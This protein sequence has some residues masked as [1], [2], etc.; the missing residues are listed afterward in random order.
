[1]TAF[2]AFIPG[3][4][5]SS[6][7]PGPQQASTVL[8]VGALQQPDSLNV[9]V[10]VETASYNIW[11]HVYELLV[12]I[13]PDTRPIPALAK[14]WSNVGNV[15]TFHLQNNVTWHDG[16]EF[17]SEDVNFTFRYIYPA[18][19][20]NPTGCDLTLLQGYIGD[21]S[22]RVG[23]DV[24][25]ITTPDKYTVVIPTYQGKANI[26]AMFVQIL[27]KHI[28]G[29]ISCQRAT[30]V[31]PTP[32][33]G[34]G[35]YKFV[36]WV[37]GSYVRLALNPNYWR[38]DKN[39]VTQDKYVG[40]ILYEYYTSSELLYR[41]FQYGLIDAT[42]ALGA[43]E[44]LTLEAS[45]MAGVTYLRSPGNQMDEVGAC[46]AS[47]A[48]MMDRLNGKVG[49]RNWLV[50][51]RTIRQAMQLAVD[52]QF[53]VDNIL[54]T[55]QPGSGLGIPGSSLIPPA[56]PFWHLNVTSLDYNV[57]RARQLLDDPKGDGAPLKD[58]FATS[59]NYGENLDATD[60]LNRDAFAA[61]NPT[62]PNVRVPVDPTQV[63]TGDEWGATGGA[64]APNR[65][66]P[67]P[68]SFG[69][70]TIDTETQ[71]YDAAIRMAQYWRDIGIQVTVNV[72]SE[73]KMISVTY[74]CDEDFYIWSWGGDIDPDF[75]L[76]VMTTGQIL[77]WQDAWYSN[78]TYDDWYSLQQTQTDPYAR[79]ATIWAMQ[80]K[81]YDDAAYL[82]MWYDDFLTVVRS[83]RFT[84]WQD[85]GTWIDH[86]GLDIAGY[87]NDL[88]MLTLRAAGAPP[89][90]NNCPTK[91]RIS[92][93]PPIAVFTNTTV[94]F[95][96][97]STDPDAGQTLSWIWAWDDATQFR[98]TTDSSVTQTNANHSWS[99]PR[100]YNVTLS[101]TDGICMVGSDP[102]RV[103]VLAVP[104]VVGYLEGTVTDA[105]TAQALIGASVQA[106]PGNWA[107]ATVAQGHYNITLPPG[108]YTVTATMELYAPASAS[109]QV[110]TAW[111][112]TVVDLQLTSFAGWI[113]GTVTS[114]TGG[115]LQGVAI[116]AVNG[117]REYAASTDAQGKYNVSVAPGIYD[118]N[119]SLSGYYTKE[120]TGKQVFADQTTVV[121]F[122]L[123]PIPVAA[124]GLSTLQVAAIV[125]VVLA[126]AIG[127]TAFV[128]RR[129]RKKAEEIEGPPLPPP[130]QPG[131]P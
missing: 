5:G 3:A 8:R 80:Q 92:G 103:D 41:D 77:Y 112:A 60:P 99:L 43:K 122:A 12:G 119:A 98:N 38:L 29:G 51:N 130:K 76:S 48:L 91:P 113:A 42:G 22:R 19:A 23:V 33:I 61:V 89:P 34:T 45:G 15:W 31:Q 28:W 116:Y 57:A 102:F 44:F 111:N 74:A 62:Y 47:D 58:G 121:D 69:L 110:V 36:E 40:E 1:M 54:G 88:V 82:I 16:V 84:G 100:S 55:Q 94:A 128:V 131:T 70:D 108:T 35:M 7:G 81:L 59:G 123:D 79:Q 50:T 114:S 20:Q 117:S 49:N 27:P 129:R 13:G 73:S 53:L 39:L 83:D 67:Y 71:A 101:V 64:S 17:T 11:A 63:Q 65:A 24:G 126:A 18:T 124:P 106:T 87:G 37:Q 127:A 26:L 93:T 78:Q 46:L 30:H 56:L 104:A 21:Y 2:G 86:P 25:N 66:S 115:V 95:S 125:A 105:D 14:D 68:L 107:N 32:M 75:I 10:G 85:F 52:R 109:G 118:V 4:R 6:V 120:V 97:V 9:F 90:P 72:V 96:G